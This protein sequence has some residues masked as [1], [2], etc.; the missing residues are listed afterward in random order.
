MQRNA[1]RAEAVLKQIANA[2]RLMILC[3]LVAGEKSV[4]ELEALV[5]LS[6]SALSQ[7]LS[8]L[9]AA[10]LIRSEKRGKMVYY[11]ICSTEAQALLST[12]YMVFCKK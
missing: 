11:R 4:S 2:K 3:N 7:H 9:R 5:N 8:K 6:Q 10:G 1:A 12:V